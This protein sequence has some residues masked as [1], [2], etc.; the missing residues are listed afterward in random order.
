MCGNPSFQNAFDLWIGFAVSELLWILFWL[1]LSGV[2]HKN[3]TKN[4]GS[5][6]WKFEILLEINLHYFWSSEFDLQCIC[7]V[8][9]RL[10]KIWVA[11]K[12]SKFHIVDKEQQ[13]F[14]WYH[15]AFFPIVE[16]YLT[17]GASGARKNGQIYHLHN[18]VVNC[19]EEGEK[20]RKYWEF[21]E[22]EQCA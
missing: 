3:V 12:F 10:F 4:M 1:F 17:D 14:F 6:M 20:K 16:P 8:F 18:S 15:N 21:S 7:L 2:T 11:N 9:Q 22:N 13:F 19:K 5:T